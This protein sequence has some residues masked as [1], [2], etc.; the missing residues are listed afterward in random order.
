MHCRSQAK[1]LK[2][3]KQL[4][5]AVLGHF[6]PFFRPRKT[7]FGTCQKYIFWYF[8]F[9]SLW[10][11]INPRIIKACQSMSKHVKAYQC[12]SKHV[13]ACQSMSKHVKASQSKSKHVK[14]CQIMS[15]HVKFG[16]LSVVISVTIESQS[17]SHHLAHEF[18]IHGLVHS[19]YL[20][21][22][23]SR[24]VLKKTNHLFGTYYSK[25]VL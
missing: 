18:Q 23:I 2:H 11:E 13:K 1:H 20:V 7:F 12:M 6:I 8:V 15:K 10:V 5:N 9:S 21:Q 3:L 4:K 16:W 14:A 24:K 22:N 17:S 19:Y 25:Y